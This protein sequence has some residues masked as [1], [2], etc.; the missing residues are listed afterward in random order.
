MSGFFGVEN[1]FSRDTAWVEFMP[2]G[3]SSTTQPVNILSRRGAG[4]HSGFPVLRPNRVSPRAIQ[5]CVDFGAIVEAAIGLEANVGREPQIDALGKL[6]AQMFFVAVKRRQN[7]GDVLAAERHDV[8]RGEL[9]IGASSALPESSR[10]GLR[11]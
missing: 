9:Q 11:E 7:I 8:N 6:T 2:D 4:C 10:P 3:L 5:T 1:P